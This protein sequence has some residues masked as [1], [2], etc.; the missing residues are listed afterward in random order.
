MVSN[1]A[2]VQPPEYFSDWERTVIIP[3]ILKG[4]YDCLAE[5]PFEE[6]NNDMWVWPN[7]IT[8]ELCQNAPPALFL[9]SEFDSC[10]KAATQ[11]AEVYRRNKRLLAF[12]ITPGSAHFDYSNY[13]L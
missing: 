6:C 1:D 13:N 8:D 12:G 5:R 7:L 3:E 2:L 9:T 11:G 4:I 10:R